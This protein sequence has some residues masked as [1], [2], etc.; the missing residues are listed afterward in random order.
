MQKPKQKILIAMAHIAE[1]SEAVP[2]GA[3]SV[4]A[5]L[6]SSASKNTDFSFLLQENYIADGSEAILKKIL[7]KQP[8]MV[9]FSMYSWNRFLLLEVAKKIRS[10]NPDILLFCGG[11]EVTALPNGLSI[12]EGGPFDTVIL[13]EG[14]KGTCHFISMA[15]ANKEFPAVI[16]TPLMQAEELARLP[17]PWLEGILE[18][19]RGRGIVWE[20]GRG[21][22]YSCSYCYESKGEKKVRYFPDERLLK[23]LRFFFK[24]NPPSVTVLD[25]TFNTN[26]KRALMILDMIIREA[27]GPHWHFEVRGELLTHE[28]ARRF[29]RLRSSLQI[30]LQSSNPEIC[31]LIGR[32]FKRGRFEKG[33][34][35]LH[36][37]GITFGLDLIYGLPGDT[38]AG[39]RKSLDYA[40]SLYPD[41]LDIFRLSVLPGTSLY[42][43]AKKLG[44]YADPNAPYYVIK[45]ETFPEKDIMAAER[46]SKAAALFY[47]RGRAVA[48]FN[49][50]LYPISKKPSVFLSG[51]ADYMEEGDPE[52]RSFWESHDF[53]NA[54]EFLSIEIEQFQLAYISKMYKK[55]RKEYLLPAVKD[56]VRF[57][58]AWGRA[59]VEGVTTKTDFSYDPE[60]LCES[61]AIDMEG[62]VRESGISKRSIVIRPGPEEP[63]VLY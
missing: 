50:L 44:V 16:R 28:Q 30:G 41:S 37:E 53:D 32:D 23:E 24:T 63:E 34:H 9:G 6:K 58:G 57:H 26:N 18:I 61:G 15:L 20:L 17:S 48:W 39:Y 38:L 31:S 33:I 51:F 10:I 60:L 29:A 11:P 12:K 19:R 2:L 55:A 54:G 22:P 59:L 7:N 52:T 62:F 21:C 47:N 3:A 45:T 25:P 43:S 14:E 35:F 8:D 46:L 13:G 56:I 40:I 5:A 4:I 49:Q 27:P 36:E 42:S 1:D